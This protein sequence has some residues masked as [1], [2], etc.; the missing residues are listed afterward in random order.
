MNAVILNGFFVGLV[1]GLLG[2]GLVVVY[3]GSRV[4]NFAYGETGML[5]AFVFADIRFGSGSAALARDHGLLVALPVAVIIAA[6]LGALTERMV[7]R[8]LRSAPR[9]RPLVGTFA[10]GSLFFIFA[11]RR[12]G[13]N[14][15]FS[16]PLV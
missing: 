9:I 7:V 3:R 1:Y 11:A 4:I 10:V 5:G 12:W 16:A 2:V 15:R 14:A 6:A 8:P 13:L